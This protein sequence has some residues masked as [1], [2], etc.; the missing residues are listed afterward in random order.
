MPWKD[1]NMTLSA[2]ITPPLLSGATEEPV[3]SLYQVAMSGRAAEINMESDRDWL[4]SV[5][6]HTSP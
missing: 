1:R 5:M 4:P 3:Y 2:F 6:R